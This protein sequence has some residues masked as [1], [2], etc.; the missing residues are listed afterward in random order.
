VVVKSMPKKE[1][2]MEYAVFVGALIAVGF[3]CFRWG[4]SSKESPSE[5]A[6]IQ[7]LIKS[8]LSS[9]TENALRDDLERR[10]NPG[11]T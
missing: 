1:M 2:A 8:R 5:E 10:I 11:R 3:L 4:Q 6:M 7:R 9:S